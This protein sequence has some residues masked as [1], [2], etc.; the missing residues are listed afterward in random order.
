MSIETPREE[1]GIVGVYG[2]PEASTLVYLGLQALQHRGQESAG[3]VSSD[4]QAQQLYKARGLVSE[5]FNEA[6]LSQLR[7]H[8][9]IG[10][11]RYSTTGSNRA[12]NA[13]PIRVDYKGGS[14]AVAHNGNIINAAELRQ[15]LEHRGAIFTSTNDS[16]IIV[17]L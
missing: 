7:G 3:I 6:N 2:N 5:V 9:A 14:L 10:H 4:G 12:V 15:E 16:E 17:H 11:V 8:I 1:C 13:Q